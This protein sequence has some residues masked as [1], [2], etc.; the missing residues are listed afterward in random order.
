[1]NYF[2]VLSYAF[3]I[4]LVLTRPLMHLAPKQWN[5][6]ELNRAY[7]EQQP[8]WLWPLGSVNL[9]IIIYTW[10]KHFTAGVPYSIIMAV[11]VTLT[12]IKSSQLLF[13]YQNF[14]KWVYKVLVEDRRQLV[15]INIAT[16][17]LGIVLIALGFFVY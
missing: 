6:F 7:T 17:I 1:M 3:G 2:E 5:E 9:A 13:N 4:V 15:K 8:K 11:F 12:L 16:T 10:Y 14:R